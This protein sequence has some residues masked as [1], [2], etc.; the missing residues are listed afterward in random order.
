MECHESWWREEASAAVEIP[1]YLASALVERASAVMGLVSCEGALIYVNRKGRSVLGVGELDPEGVPLSHLLFGKSELEILSRVTSVGE[2]RG[3][4]AFRHQRSGAAIIME[5][6]FCALAE[7][8]IRS[9]P[10][11]VLEARMTEERRDEE[12]RSRDTLVR[13]AKIETVAKRAGGISDQFENLLTAI[14]A[15]SGECL[16]SPAA[17]IRQLLP[18]GRRQARARGHELPPRP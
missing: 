9:V 5:A 11:T 16:S 15:F 2:W 18:V 10:V 3:E 17:L 8:G 13:A 4:I 6:A 14:S 7:D 12:P 1:G